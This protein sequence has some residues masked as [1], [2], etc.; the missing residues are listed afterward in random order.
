MKE[1]P[2]TI[3]FDDASF[4]LKS[5]SKTTYLI[6]VV[7]QGFRMA[8]VIKAEIKIDGYDSTE[9][10]IELVVENQKH[11]QYI[12]THTITFGGFNLINLRKIYK[13][14]EKPI[15]A[16][17]DR[18]VDLKAVLNT[19]KQKFPK[20]YKQKVRNIINAGNLYQTKIQ[21]AGGLSSLY[22]HKK[23]IKI[24][25]VETL[26]QKTCIDSKLPECIRI[27]HLIGKMF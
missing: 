20:N 19:L 26:L 21:T 18:N 3:G 6:G 4:N 11:V 9:K 5:G 7:C 17:N 2:I 15:I 8:K 10:L 14:T 1:N 13:E 23:G 27:A 16:I 12:L 25:E 22:F 24:H